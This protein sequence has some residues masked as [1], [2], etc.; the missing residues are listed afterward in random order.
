[1]QLG[2]KSIFTVPAPL[3]LTRNGCPASI[4]GNIP[5]DQ[6]LRFDIELIS[7]TNDILHDQSILKKII[8]FGEETGRHPTGLDEVFGTLLFY[9]FYSRACF[10]SLEFITADF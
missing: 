8:K 9:I 3:A 2:E 1:M 6:T 7:I 10:I 4:P 5:P